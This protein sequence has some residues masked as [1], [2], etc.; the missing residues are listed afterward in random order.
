[1]GERRKKNET[2]AVLGLRF[3]EGIKGSWDRGLKPTRR[4]FF[5]PA[6]GLLG[7][8]DLKTDGVINH[9]LSLRYNRHFDQSFLHSKKRGRGQHNHASR[10]LS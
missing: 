9:Q 1:V 6:K 2:V 7:G 10:E 8:E 5:C 3:Y 4:A